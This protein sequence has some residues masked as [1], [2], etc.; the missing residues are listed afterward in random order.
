[1]MSMERPYMLVEF[2]IVETWFQE[3]VPSHEVCYIVFGGQ[4][5][6]HRTYEYLV[7]PS[8]GS[9]RWVSAADGQIPSGAVHGGRASSD[10]PLF[11]GRAYY[12]V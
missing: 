8:Y 3:T 10:E 9:L 1:M 6:A 11:I 2:M 4:E 7:S 12:E 5:R